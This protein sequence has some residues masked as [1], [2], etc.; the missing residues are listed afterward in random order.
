MIIEPSSNARPRSSDT[1]GWPNIERMV[2]LRM[3]LCRRLTVLP[4]CASKIFGIER[5]GELPVLGATACPS[6]R[7][8]WHSGLAWPRGR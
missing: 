7:K 3:N 4:I 1:S 5:I 6:S 2:W 8:S